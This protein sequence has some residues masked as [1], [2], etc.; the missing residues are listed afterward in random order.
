MIEIIEYLNTLVK[1]LFCVEQVDVDLKLSQNL[2][3]GDYSSA[4]AFFLAKKLGKSPIECAQK[5]CDSIR[6][7]DIEKATN[8]N[9]YVN[10]VIS[11]TKIQEDL[12]KFVGNNKVIVD[13][14][15]QGKKVQVEFISANPTGPLHVG[16]ARGGPIGETL[17]N[18]YQALGAQVE[19]EF[20]VNDVGGQIEKFARSIWYHIAQKIERKAD[21]PEDGYTG[22][23]IEALSLELL[24]KIRVDI[25]E[26]QDTK[27]IEI[28]K[29]QS[30]E[31]VI[32][33]LK[34][35]IDKLGISFDK[36]IYQ[37]E[38]AK[39]TPDIINKLKDANCTQE[40]DGALWF[41]DQ[42]DD[43]DSVLVK[44]DGEYTYYADDIAY[45][46]DKF[47]TRN[48]D[49]VVDI[50][51]AN[52]HGHVSRIKRALEALGI[53]SKKLEIVLYQYV[54]L[55]NGLLIEKMAKRK[56]TYIS[57]DMV[58][59]NIPAEVFKFFMLARNVNTHLDFDYQKALDSTID[60]P[61][62]YCFY[63]IARI[64]SIGEKIKAISSTEKIYLGDEISRAIALKILAYNSL[65]IEVSSDLAVSKLTN[66]SIE[67]S[68]LVHNFY[69]SN[70]VLASQAEQEKINLL[71]LARQILI[72]NFNIMGINPPTKLTK[73]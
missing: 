30:V 44:T 64:N 40:K 2:K 39:R 8:E 26:A 20:Y 6:N 52:H 41:K 31:M 11:D 61:I 4:V 14:T 19:R 60:N 67:L 68:R 59:E 63:A 7:T 1:E 23:Y 65:L 17:S 38:I 9:G 29:K 22:E 10:L 3:F 36:Y 13:K 58:L 55:K 43:K 21:Y 73:K 27:I 49:K 51:G 24:E 34:K 66:Y 25:E 5:I 50:W 70:K 56:G 57:A 33:Q 16:N 71:N 62:Y 35:T 48:F 47:I 32:N 45:H 28:I 37:S 12:R 53:D 46:F 18:I 15:Y 42:E 72:Y 54:R 69:E